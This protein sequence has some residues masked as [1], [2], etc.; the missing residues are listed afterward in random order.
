[1]K[2][3]SLALVSV[4]LLSC[5][6]ARAEEPPSISQ[7]LGAVQYAPEVK[8]ALAVPRESGPKAAA[9]SVYQ[10]QAYATR[11]SAEKEMRSC[12]AN[13]SGMGVRVS[14]SFVDEIGDGDGRVYRFVLSFDG[15][16]LRNYIFDGFPA[17]EKAD[18]VRDKGL[19]AFKR[20]GFPVVKY[21]IQRQESGY[22]VYIAYLVKENEPL[23][24]MDYL[25]LEPDINPM[26]DVSALTTVGLG[27]VSSRLEVRGLPVLYGLSNDAGTRWMVRFLGKGEVKRLQSGGFS[28][29]TLALEAAGAKVAKLKA[30]PSVVLLDFKVRLI[31]AFYVIDYLQL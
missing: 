13:L 9:R 14:G 30:D 1:M 8:P 19:E 15:W 12:V 17:K 29:W 4:L 23:R 5:G 22:G 18:E 24:E 31:G 27:E 11:E 7:L 28:A 25:S 16:E 26:V 21:G 3:R 20:A 10:S 6:F 2:K